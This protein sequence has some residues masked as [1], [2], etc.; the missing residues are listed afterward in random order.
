MGNQYFASR[1]DGETFGPF[2]DADAA[3]F[4][5]VRDHAGLDA[6]ENGVLPGYADTAEEL[7]AW[8][9]RLVERHTTRSSLE[10]GAW[11][12]AAREFVR[13]ID[14]I[15]FGFEPVIGYIGNLMAPTQIHAPSLK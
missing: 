3:I 15:V 6:R 1:D 12:S 13:E 7:T 11:L 2:D 5:V 4:H 9:T 14:W 10:Y 8:Y